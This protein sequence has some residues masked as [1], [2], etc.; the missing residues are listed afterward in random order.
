MAFDVCLSSNVD[1]IFIAKVIPARIVRI[2]ACTVSIDIKLLHHLNVL[3]HSFVCNVVTLVRIYFVTVH[4]LDK[5][6]LSVYKK[7]CILDFN[8]SETDILRNNFNNLVTIL[9]CCVK[10]VEVWSFSSPLE[11]I[12]YIEIH[13]CLS[14]RNC[15][16]LLNNHLALLVLQCNSDLLAFCIG[17]CELHVECTVLVLAV[18]IR[19]NKEILNV[20]CRTC[21]QI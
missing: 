9:Q 7:L 2:V 16:S 1:T 8:L 18:K 4:T 19:S 10:L 21:I 5:Y 14:A 20:A 11:R 15:L 3:N 12:L 17:S 13:F 6:R